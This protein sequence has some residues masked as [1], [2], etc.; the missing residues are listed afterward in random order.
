MNLSRLL[1]MDVAE[2]QAVMEF[3]YW[4]VTTNLKVTD[5]DETKVPKSI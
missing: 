3:S 5:V 2:L 4:E 1:I